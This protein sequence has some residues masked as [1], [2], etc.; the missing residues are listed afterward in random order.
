M[1]FTQQS[2]RRRE[3]IRS[4]LTGERTCINCHKDIA[5]EL[6]DMTGIAPGWIVPDELQDTAGYN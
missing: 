1:D 2:S 5:H 4:C 3:S 6:L